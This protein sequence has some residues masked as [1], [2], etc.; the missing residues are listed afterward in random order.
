M[1]YTIAALK[2]SNKMFAFDLEKTRMWAIAAEEELDA[3][4]AEVKEL[5]AEINKL[6]AELAEANANAAK[7]KADLLTCEAEKS[8][9]LE[10]VNS[11]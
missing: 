2:E 4:K 7:A 1:E 10:I 3:A 9:L 11:S 6:R 8:I 5:L